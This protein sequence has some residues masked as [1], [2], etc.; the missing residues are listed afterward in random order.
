MARKVDFLFDPFEIAGV[1]KADLDK[2]I[3]TQALADVRDYIL[4]DTKFTSDIRAI[5][6]AAIKNHINKTKR[7]PR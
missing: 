2:S 7:F 3:V 4:S 1:N 6:M 5:I